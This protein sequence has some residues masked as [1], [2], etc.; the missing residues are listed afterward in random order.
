MTK[1]KGTNPDEHYYIDR[2]RRRIGRVVTGTVTG[3]AVIDGIVEVEFEV[4]AI[5][6]PPGST[7]LSPDLIKHPVP[8]VGSEE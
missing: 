5:G 4:P 8:R 1:E 3:K 7:P 6:I 2:K